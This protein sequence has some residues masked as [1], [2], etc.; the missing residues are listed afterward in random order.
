MSNCHAAVVKVIE[1]ELQSPF[2]HTA[3]NHS[4]HW[5]LAHNFLLQLPNDFVNLR[6]TNF[7]L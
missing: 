2:K 5:I 3:C 4:L 7:E 6:Q 1:M